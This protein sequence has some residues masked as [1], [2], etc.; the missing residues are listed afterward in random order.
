MNK[1]QIA[2]FRSSHGLSAISATR[3][4]ATDVIAANRRKA[5]AA[6]RAAHAQLQRDIK[7]KR[8]SKGR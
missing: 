6:N 7:S 5:Q 1:D 4:P 2:A 3:D 8:G